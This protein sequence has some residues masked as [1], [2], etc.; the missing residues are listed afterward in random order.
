[1]AAPAKSETTRALV[2][3]GLW[4]NNPVLRQLLGICSTLAV[5][6]LLRNTLVMGVG[7]VYVTALSSWT[8]SLLRAYTPARVRMMVQ[9]LII[10]TYVIVLD[11]LLKRFSP[12]ISQELGAYVGLIIT[13]CIVMGRCEGF[14]TSRRPWPALVDGFAQGAGYTLVLLAI[15]LVREVMG[16]GTLLGCRVL[17]GW[18]TPWLIM[19]MPAAGFFMLA[20]FLWIARGCFPLPGDRAGGAK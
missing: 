19:V 4:E 5:T 15:A 17:G 3:Q 13:N 2:W 7:L 18:W 16:A 14:A 1:M 10:S 12:E 20:S 11:L 6:N 8:V 9:L